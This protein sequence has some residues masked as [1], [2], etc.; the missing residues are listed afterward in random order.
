MSRLMFESRGNGLLLTKEVGDD[1]S[2]LCSKVLPLVLPP[3]R[4]MEFTCGRPHVTVTLT[5][6][7]A[8]T[9]AQVGAR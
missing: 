7:H 6:F 9:D 4:S 2:E 3:N 1:S 8:V 5:P